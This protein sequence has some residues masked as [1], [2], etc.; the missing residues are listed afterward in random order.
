MKAIIF[1]TAIIICMSFTIE[2]NAQK[3]ITW[4]GGTPGQETKWNCPKNWDNNSVP[5]EF[6]NVVIP[7]VSGSTQSAPRIVSGT[8]EVNSIF[9]FSNAKFE[10]DEGAKVIV[11]QPIIGIRN[12]NANIRGKV[13]VNST[14]G[15]TAQAER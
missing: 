14:N 3:I 11:Y 12:S 7:D 15:A 1:S 5:N 2:T 9:I 13:I 8:V 6:S 10:V 4:K